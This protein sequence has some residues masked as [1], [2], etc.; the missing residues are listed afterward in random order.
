MFRTSVILFYLLL[1]QKISSQVIH[2]GLEVSEKGTIVFSRAEENRNG[3][4]ED[5]TDVTCEIGQS[6]YQDDWRN[7]KYD[8]LILMDYPDE[9][10]TMP[11]NGDP[12]YEGDSLPEETGKS[13]K[14][15][16]VTVV[17]FTDTLLDDSTRQDR[18]EPVPLFRDEIDGLGLTDS[19]VAD[20]REKLETYICENY[21][22]LTEWK[23]QNQLYTALSCPDTIIHK[24]RIYDYLVDRLVFYTYEG[25]RLTAVTA[26]HWNLGVECDSLRYDKYGNLRYLTREKV[27]SI[28]YEYCFDYNESNQLIESTFV[29]CSAGSIPYE[30]F[31]KDLPEVTRFGYDASG[32]IC[33]KSVVTGTGTW[34]NCYFRRRN[35]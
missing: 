20:A 21:G 17:L 28:R 33:S 24:Q 2:Y 10:W 4:L 7:V 35:H 31:G 29:Y 13:G 12:G 14:N 30:P 27:G 26:Y 11:S 3:I 8:F 19:R 9:T 6:R 16:L 15:Q 22:R 5:T 34:N 18:I 1:S 32:T 23:E 25:D